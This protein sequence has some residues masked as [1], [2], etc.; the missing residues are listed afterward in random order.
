MFYNTIFPKKFNLNPNAQPFVPENCSPPLLVPNNCLDN[1]EE[2]FNINLLK[3]YFQNITLSQMPSSSSHNIKELP[4]NSTYN[5]E[6]LLKYKS[7]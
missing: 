7:K 5:Y 4:S 1:K 2:V 6:N 3:S